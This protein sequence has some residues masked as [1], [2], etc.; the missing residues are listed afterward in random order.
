MTRA[1]VA[2]A[3]IALAAAAVLPAGAEPLDWRFALQPGV[4]YPV[5]SAGHVYRSAFA[6]S[7][8]GEYRFRPSVSAGLELGYMSNGQ[9]GDI[10][11]ADFR[12]DID[13]TILEA[14]PFVRLS[15]GTLDG[16]VGWTRYF[17]FG[18]GFYERR[19]GDGTRTF[20]GSGTQVPVAA[21]DWRSHLGLSAG[22]GAAYCLSANWSVGLDFRYHHIF[23]TEDIDF[24]GTG[25]DPIQVVVASGRLQ[26]RF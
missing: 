7:G 19:T 8:S 1:A 26:Y 15:A 23:T 25:S 14:S 9:Q 10:N 13:Q 11:G 4:S 17:L 3:V 21:S 2:A 22:V 6:M 16:G 24:S 18:A 12:S 5:G 20:S